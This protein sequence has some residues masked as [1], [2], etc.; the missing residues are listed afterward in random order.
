MNDEFRIAALAVISGV[1]GIAA[2]LVIFASELV[3]VGVLAGLL[4][5]A[6]LWVVGHHSEI[7]ETRHEIELL[8]YEL[9]RARQAGDERSAQRSGLVA[10]RSKLRS[11]ESAVLELIAA[12]AETSVILSAI[13]ELLAGQHAGSQFRIINDELFDAE[14]VDRS[15]TI[16]PR[17]KSDLGWVLQANLKEGATEP[18]SDV[19]TLAQDLARLT[20]DKARSR[21]HLLYQA[22]HD[23]LTGLLSRRAV[24]SALDD[25]ITSGGSIGLAYCDI[26]KFKEIN[27][28]LGHQAGD[29]LLCGIS[30]RL[31][32]A[33]SEAPFDCTVG[34]LGGDEYL[35]V[36]SGA[37]RRDMVSFVERLSFAIRVPFTFG[38]TTIS[39]SLSMGAAFT[40]PREAADPK[41]DSAELL[42]ESDLA[43][44]QVKRNGR[45]NFRF[46]D[47]ELRAILDE[48]RELQADLAKSISSRSGI[49]AMFQPQFNGDRELIGFEALGRWYRQG[50]GLV[51]PADF[52][53]VATEHGLMADFDV[54]VFNHIAQVL[55]MLR[56]EGRQF[57]TVAIN[58]SAERLEKADFVQTTLD[59]LRQHSIDPHSI[60]LEITEASLL[61]DL[62]ERGKR[63][64]ELR[65]WGVRIAIDDFGTGYSSLSYLRELPVD[66]VK[67]DKDFVSDID[68][69]EES[70]AIVHAIL[71]L[72]N[73]LDLS[74]VAEGVE[75]ESQ[76]DVLDELGCTIFQGY[77]LGRPLELAD[78]RSLA[79]GQ[80]KTDPFGSAYEWDEQSPNDASMLHRT[81]P[82]VE[83]VFD[84][85]SESS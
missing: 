17:T 70:R 67:L 85:V 11:D 8:D 46:F 47:D 66:I 22:D 52:L 76:Y 41:P 56:R 37:E 5:A 7:S 61:R 80:W 32:E 36:A 48:Q 16:L 51:Q 43:L 74:V 45:N 15:W 83:G 73:A 62:H 71:A 29:D 39:T 82:A 79:G 55:G 30:T 38:G 1:V 13:T 77:L 20:V 27:D 53:T 18:Q 81:T 72:A 21:T 9:G 63:L 12:D 26:D 24:L 64:E 34:R 2:V 75:R 19:L 78:A 6:G 65:T 40:L 3:S 68:S 59:V 49:H 84:D 4:I 33:A 50:L 54:E 31:N 23:A 42:K 44:Y 60:V 10:S 35:I 25:A 28:T 57:G 14:T 58:V 69:S